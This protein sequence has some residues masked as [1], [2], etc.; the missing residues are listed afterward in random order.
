MRNLFLGRKFVV[1]LGVLF[2]AAL[3]LSLR[4]MPQ[5]VNVTAPFTYPLINSS[6]F[7]AAATTGASVACSAAPAGFVGM[8]PSVTTL[9]VNTTAV[10]ANSQIILQAD[11]SLGTALGE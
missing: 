11:S 4:A 8:A 5:Q 6:S 9:T 1:L 10:T 3:L 2:V 7:C